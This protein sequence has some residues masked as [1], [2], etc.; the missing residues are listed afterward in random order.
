MFR[1][2]RV[3]LTTLPH[4]FAARADLLLEGLALRQQLASVGKR[5]RPTIRFADRL[6]WVL[7]RRTWSRW[8][9]VLLIVKPDMVAGWHR[10]GKIGLGAKRSCVIAYYSRGPSGSRWT[11]K[12]DSCSG[13]IRTGR[14]PQVA[15]TRSSSDL[16]TGEI[17]HASCRAGRRLPNSL[18]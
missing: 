9:E 5:R 6:F 17:A 14:S 8:S 16:P 7:L 11:G 4:L 15:T 13:P 2:L 12:E 18:T 10:A 3:I 1:L